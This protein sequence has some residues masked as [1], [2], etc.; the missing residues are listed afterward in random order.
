[1]SAGRALQRLGSGTLRALSPNVW[2]PQSLRQDSAALV[3]APGYK[4]ACWH[5]G[6]FVFFFCRPD[7]WPRHLGI[8]SIEVRPC[9]QMIQSAESPCRWKRR[10]PST[11]PWRTPRLNEDISIAKV[12]VGPQER[13]PRWEVT[14]GGAS[15]EASI[16]CTQRITKAQMCWQWCT[17]WGQILLEVC[18]TSTTL[19]QYLHPLSASISDA[20][21]R[22]PVCSE[23]QIPFVQECGRDLHLHYCRGPAW[24][25]DDLYLSLPLVTC[26]SGCVELTHSLP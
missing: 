14:V 5:S 18:M 3:Q 4:D 19:L 9:V 7:N 1:M 15:S 12:W 2:K 11:E 8:I 23:I 21:W 25:W 24:R 13:V 22:Q 6:F 10:G 17:S 16:R 26:R 20:C